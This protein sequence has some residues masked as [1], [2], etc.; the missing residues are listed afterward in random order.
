MVGI[1]T[2]HGLIGTFIDESGQKIEGVQ[3]NDIIRQIHAAA[4]ADS[5]EVHIDSPGGECDLGYHIYDLLKAAKKPIH[6]IIDNECYSIATVPFLAGDT[7]EIG[8]N[9]KGPMI[10]PPWGTGF[11]GNASELQ[12]IAEDLQSEQN[13]MVDFYS[14]VTGVQKPLIEALMRQESYLSPSDSALYNFTTKPQPQIIAFAFNKNNM[15]KASDKMKDF[16]AKM[17]GDKKP[18]KLVALAVTDD[19][20]VAM[21]IQS[22]DDMPDVGN[23]VTVAGAP[24]PD[25][26]Y[27]ITAAGIVVTVVAGVISEIEDISAGP[28]GDDMVAQIA[29]LKAENETLKIA[30]AEEKTENEEIAKTFAMIE[31]AMP[32]GYKVPIRAQVFTKKVVEEVVVTAADRKAVYKKKK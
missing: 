21:D 30:L 28:G 31:K 12:A 32:E 13:K 19:N 2:I 22:V 26:V 9:G 27:P 1:I 18:V 6:T 14:K 10:H 8:P 5:L 16:L 15:G 7:R 4:D 29:A 20:G 11:T 23:P 17:A 25:G 24:A 3:A